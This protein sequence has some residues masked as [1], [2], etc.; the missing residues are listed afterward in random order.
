MLKK[1]K[2]IIFIIL[3]SAIGFGL[4]Q[5]PFTTII[6]SNLK[7]SLF[8]FYGPIAAG[9]IGSA[10]GV[11]AV[12][13]MQISNW[14]I[15]GFSIDTATLIRFLPMVFAALYFAKKSAFNLAIPMIAMLAFW[16]HP[17]GQKAWYY[18]LYW[19]IPMVMYVF[20]ERFI[21]ARALGTTF[22]A[23]AVGSALW[24][25]ILPMPAAVWTSLI[26]VVWKERGLMAIGMTL[27]FIACNYLLALLNKKYH[28]LDFVQIYKKSLLGIKQ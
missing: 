22:T 10:W 5:I 1:Y 20:R 13:I 3:F 28:W 14:A 16:L 24:I 15:H 27:T 19:L 9:F 7:F 8:D 4:M 21:F 12:L 11:V 6:G 17:E 23:H 18:A 25:W 26:P 2:K